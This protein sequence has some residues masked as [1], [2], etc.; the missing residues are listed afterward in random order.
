VLTAHLT[1]VDVPAAAA[2]AR[3]GC[4]LPEA[5]VTMSPGDPV[6]IDH[7]AIGAVVE[8]ITT[9]EATLKVIRTKPGGQH[10]GAEKGINLPE[11]VLPLNAL[12]LEDGANLLFVAGHADLVAI[13]FVRTAEDVE[14]VLDRLTA[15][16][17]TDLRAQRSRG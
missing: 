17:A 9:G 16:G 5:V 3:I 11:T 14:H 6:L 7:G 12:T 10:L 8:S 1:P 2:V 13:S 4:T 15:A